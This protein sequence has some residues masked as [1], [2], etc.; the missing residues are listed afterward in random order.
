[1]DRET[2][3]AVVANATFPTQRALSTSLTR[4]SEQCK[5]QNIGPPAIVI[6]G[7]GAD[8]DDRLNWFM[9]KSL[10][11][12]NIVVTRDRRGNAD[13]AAKIIQRGANPIQF[14][15]IKLKPL[16]GGNKF[17]QTLAKL[18]E[19][20]WIIFTSANGVTIFFDCLHSLQ[21]DGRVFGPAKIA[22]IGSET[23]RRLKNFGIKADFLPTVFTGRELGKQLIGFTNLQGKKI[24][25][26]RSQLASNELAEMLEQAAAKV[27]D[28]PVYTA[29]TEK[30]E[31]AWLKDNIADG[32]VDWLT[33]ASPS[34]AD[35][36]F[37]RIKSDLVNSGNVRV[38]SIGPVT[39]GQLKNLGVRIDIEAAEHTI[40]GLL[41]AIE[42]T[43]R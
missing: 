14:P 19:Y 24:L 16:T 17:L 26:L 2:P 35:A 3:A 41:D 29:V 25:L 12:R 28:V 4:L 13:F 1:M 6:I 11:G 22:A 36:F 40:D 5:Q 9:K 34:S 15:T 21:K 20:D 23:A 39:S 7:A 27:D 8:S 18:V 37:E 38:A 10:F 33:F 30:V 31:C 42:R 43:Y 32:V